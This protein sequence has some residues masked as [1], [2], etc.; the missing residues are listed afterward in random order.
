MCRTT[1]VAGHGRSAT[2]PASVSSRTESRSSWYLSTEPSV[3]CTFST[4]S[5][6]SPSAVS[7]CAQSIVSASPGGFCRSSSAQLRDERGRLGGQ[8]LG[9]ARHAQL[10]DLDLALE[11]RV[12]DPVEEAAALERVVQLARPVRGQDHVRPLLRLDRAELGNR[13]LEVRQHLEQ[14]RLELLVGAVDLVD[15]EH[16]GLLG[17]DRLEQRPPDQELAGRTAPPRRRFPPARRGCAAAGARS[18]TRRR[19]ARRR[20]PRSTGAGSAARRAPARSPSPPRSCRRR[21]RPRAAAASRASA[22]DRARSRARGRADTTLRR[23]PTRAR[24]SRRTARAERS[25][26]ASAV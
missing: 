12:A 22:R 1:R 21:P 2:S 24:R 25:G 19:R 26:S 4:S 3:A 7:A 16:D 13:D 15:Q 23:A 8:P 6:C 10:H 18:S 14:E 20:G 9:H 11:R 5:S 17:L